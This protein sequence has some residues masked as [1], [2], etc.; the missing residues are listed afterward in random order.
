MPTLRDGVARLQRT[1]PR[2]ERWWLTLLLPYV[3]LL[4]QFGLLL[5]TRDASLL[6][7]SAAYVVA[8]RGLTLLFVASLSLGVLGLYFD[9]QYVAANSDWWPSRWYVLM[10]FLPAVGV[11]VLGTYLARRERHVGLR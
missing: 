10:F 11:L 9:R 3:V 4:V 2:Y 8:A 6:R 7:S 1:A 5:S